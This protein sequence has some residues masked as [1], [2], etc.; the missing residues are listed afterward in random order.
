VPGVAV[1]IQWALGECGDADFVADGVA[2]TASVDD[3][4]MRW[5]KH[6]GVLS[7]GNLKMKEGR[8]L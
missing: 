3:D 4:G 8:V 2:V 7:G 6:F 1:D 5:E